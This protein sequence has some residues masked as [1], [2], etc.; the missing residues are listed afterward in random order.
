MSDNV[1][2]KDF[3]EGFAQGLKSALDSK[4]KNFAEELS[5]R[6]LDEYRNKLADKLR[7]LAASCTMEI[8]K[9][10]ELMYDKDRLTIVIH[11][12]EPPKEQEK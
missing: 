12:P 7:V 6:L 3:R 8:Y 9:T 4:I 1:T 5:D 2:P 11:T 10:M